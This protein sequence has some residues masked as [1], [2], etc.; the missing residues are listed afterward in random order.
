MNSNVQRS[1]T[2]A[3]LAC[4]LIG[5]YFSLNWIFGLFM[6]F[7]ILNDLY[8]QETYMFGLLSRSDFPVMYWLVMACWLFFTVSYFLPWE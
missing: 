4:L 2:L 1:V 8:R 7:W 3:G 5:F 6:A